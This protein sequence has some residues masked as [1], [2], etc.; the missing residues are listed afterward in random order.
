MVQKAKEWSQAPVTGSGV[1]TACG[2]MK[3]NPES[4]LT[5]RLM[6]P[7]DDYPGAEVP[8]AFIQQV[9]DELSTLPGVLSVGAVHH[10]PL[11]YAAS[12]MGFTVED[13]P[14]EAGEQTQMHIFKHTAS[15]FFETMQIPLLA[16]RTFERA[17]HEENRGVAVISDAVARLYWPGENPIGKRIQP[18]GADEQG[19]DPDLWHTIIGVVGNVRNLDLE[20]EDGEIVYLTMRPIDSQSNFA[21]RVMGFVVRTDGDPTTMVDSIRTRIQALDANLPLADIRTM[22][23][24]VA[25]A[26]EDETFMM[27]LLLIGAAGALLIGAVGIYGVV[28]YVVSQRTHEIGVR[29]ALGARTAEIGWMI[30]RRS[31]TVTLAGI[32]AG[33]TVAIALTSFMNALLYGVSPLDPLTF[34]VV[35]ATLFVVAALAAYLP[36]RRAARVDPLAALRFE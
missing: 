2:V 19:P 1:S 10:L 13:L 36:A 32:L 15:G 31:L 27:A 34:L 29:M 9:I 16:G 18:G 23:S 17:D 30:L 33:V 8:A 28:S 35:I 11:G 6:L 24:L 7:E 20:E 25:W 4:V 14:L 5:F 26:R 3:A 22:E 12:G 21:A